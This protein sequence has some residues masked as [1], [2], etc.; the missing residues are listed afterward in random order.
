MLFKAINIKIYVRSKNV[1]KDCQFGS[2]Y[3]EEGWNAFLLPGF[4]LYLGDG[5]EV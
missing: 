2:F 1:L 3:M 4:S 5:E